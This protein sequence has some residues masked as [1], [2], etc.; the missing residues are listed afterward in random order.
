MTATKR[1]KP[2]KWRDL[3]LD[4]PAATRL[5]DEAD[6]RIRVLNIAMALDEK[7]RGVLFDP[8]NLVYLDLDTVEVRLSIAKPYRPYVRHE[9]VL[10]PMVFRPVRGYEVE[11][12]GW[13]YQREA[14]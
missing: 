2:R 11:S 12:I 8:P 13:R 4:T 10:T 9:T 6:R 7:Y 1:S 5:I 14:A 3:Q